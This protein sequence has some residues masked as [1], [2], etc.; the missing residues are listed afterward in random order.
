MLVVTVACRGTGQSDRTSA[1][2][3]S[4]SVTAPG[5]ASS[6]GP[7]AGAVTSARVGAFNAVLRRAV[8]RSNLAPGVTAAV[9]SDRGVWRGAYGVSG[10]SEPLVPTSVMCVASISKTFTAAE[11]LHLAAEGKVDLDRPMSRY[12]S[13]RLTSN[14]A[15]VRQAL[16]MISG[17]LD[18]DIPGLSALLAAHPNQHL[19]VQRALDLM[20]DDQISA[21]R[22]DLALQQCQLPPARPLDRTGRPARVARCLA[23][24]PLRASRVDPSGRAG[25]RAAPGPARLSL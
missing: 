17:L 21:P 2:V 20:P 7:S 9:V 10:R 5:G 19:G 11:V 6:A 14:G 16:G 3:A 8:D 24:R 15:T 18:D 13:D 25:R 22:Q 1:S 23:H 12:V 4:G